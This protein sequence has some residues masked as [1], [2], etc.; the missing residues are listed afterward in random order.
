MSDKVYVSG[1]DFFFQKNPYYASLNKSTPKFK[2]EGVQ[3]SIQTQ[4]QINHLLYK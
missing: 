4:Q 2:V 3:S 1:H